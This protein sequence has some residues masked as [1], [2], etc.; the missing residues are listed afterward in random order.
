[1]GDSIQVLLWWLIAQVLGWITLPITFRLFRWLPDRGYTFSK[2]FGLLLVSYIYWMG[3]VSGF[4][5]NDYGGILF[6]FFLVA[7]I[8]AWMLLRT[9]NHPTSG[10]TAELLPFLR[11]NKNMI[12]VAEGLF[13]IAFVSWSV[14]RA[15]A[16][17]KIMNAG[18]EKFMEMAFLNGTLNSPSFPPIDVWLSDFAISYYYFGYVMMALITRIS[19]AFPGVGFELYDALLFSLTVLGSFGIVYNL[20]ASVK[21]DQPATAILPPANSS[22]AIHYGL[23]GSL[24]VVLLGNLEGAIESLYG[25]G[26]LP[27]SFINWLNIP[28]LARV[29]VSGSWF[30][31]TTAG[32][33]WWRASRVLQDQDLFYR[34]QGISPITEFPFFSFLLGDNHP[35]VLALPFAL[36]AIGLSLNLFI[37]PSDPPATT[38]A[39][40]WW[41]PFA[42][43]FKNRW[44]DFIFYSLCLGALGF[45]NT[46]DMPIY[47][48]LVVLAYGVKLYFETHSINA[49]FFLRLIS[50]S[51]VLLLA[52]VGLY[53]FFYISFGSQAGGILPYIF[54]PTRL[55][56]YLVMFGTFIFI[57]A[58]YLAVSYV[59]LAR[60]ASK[61]NSIR[62]FLRTWLGMVAISIG[63]VLFV[64]LLAGFSA[65]GRQ[66]I[67]GNAGDSV[68]Q[69]ILGGMTMAEFLSV[70]VL[71]RISNPYLFLLL[72]VLISLAAS[73]LYLTAHI[74]EA[75]N[76]QESHIQSQGEAFSKILLLIGLALTLSVEFLYLRDSF[77]VR[78]NTVFKF[79]YQGWLMLGLASAFGFYWMMNNA[80]GVIGKA[81]RSI[82][83]AI[84]LLLIAAGMVYP[85][86]ASA[87][88]VQGFQTIPNLDGTS[89]LSKSNP[90]DWAAIN[91]LRQQAIS[92][93]IVSLPVILEAPGKSYNYE[94]R[95]SAFSGYPAV[96]GWALHESQWRGNYDEQAKREPDI[97]TI[98]TTADGSLALDLLR[99]WQVKYL[100][101]GSVERNYIQ[102]LCSD[103]N[104]QCNL[105]RALRK[106]EATLIPVFQQGETIIYEVP[107]GL[108]P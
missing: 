97:E 30:P 95:I 13:L 75:D 62:V 45:L 40:P 86:M 85:V 54:P 74:V 87:S 27:P 94:G 39:S 19:N 76:Q 67:S 98:F 101:I 23:L 3:G 70:Y 100:I 11:S 69:S 7:S 16:S 68:V 65:A 21:R 61:T 26:L 93:G 92:P 96:L 24:F 44:F 102:Q 80:A 37:R 64:F 59:W 104:R 83:L 55:P 28:D 71:A 82:F 32:W 36:L 47:I 84:S 78:M 77:G 2:S 29:P 81:G 15:Y 17:D 38:P 91:W 53:I 88:R 57:A 12:L 108:K 31:D 106:F 33:W 43:V 9:R 25:R 99:K 42:F 105:P 35:H 66:L 79:Y 34:P 51:V 107:P 63:I 20:V 18:G 72:S 60:K 22:Q 48:G 50:L 46:W 10:P 89:N 103:P 14:L 4:I 6:A 5:R 52:C 1:M 56:Q 58:G 8:S 73:S 49:E 90:D 41:N